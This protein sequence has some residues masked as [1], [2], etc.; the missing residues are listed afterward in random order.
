MMTMVTTTFTTV[1]QAQALR[2]IMTRP[3][4]HSTM[5]KN[6]IQKVWSYHF[7]SS[8]VVTMSLAFSRVRPWPRWA[9]S[10]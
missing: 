9:Q 1:F 10:P 4:G 5:R 6:T 2:H 7:F 3:T 8:P